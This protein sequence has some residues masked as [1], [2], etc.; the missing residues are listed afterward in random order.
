MSARPEWLRA[1][2][3]GIVLGHH[4]HTAYLTTSK[5]PLLGAELLLD[6]AATTADRAAVAAGVQRG[7]AVGL[8]RD[9]ASTPGQDLVPVQLAERAVE[10]AK[11]VGAKATVLDPAAMERLGMGCVLAVGR[12]S[13]NPPRFIELVYEPTRGKRGAKPGT[14]PTVVVIGKG[15]TFDTGGVSLK[16]RDNMKK[17]KY[18]MAGSAAV[19]GMFAA[20]PTLDLPFRVVG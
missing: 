15:V 16:P 18:D 7:E 1:A 8:A 9:L 6:R 12:G 20:L 2:A 17:M 13:P 10:T 14:V 11:R 19:I 5:A 3:E 4:R